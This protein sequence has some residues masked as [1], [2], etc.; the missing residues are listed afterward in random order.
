MSRDGGFEVGDRST[1]TLSDTR[2][3]RAV[4]IAGPWTVP[5]WDAIVDASWSKGERVTLD[6]A[7]LRLPSV[8]RPLIAKLDVYRDALRTVGLL[9]GDSRI[10]QESWAVWFD[11]ANQRR[12]AKR[13]RDRDRARR[14]ADERWRNESDSPADRERPAGGPYATDRA[15]PTEPIRPTVPIRPNKGNQQPDEWFSDFG[16]VDPAGAA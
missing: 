4:A 10:R 1:A 2:L 8:Y 12:E 16:R 7:V 14:A 11:P 3:I 13:K 6:D 5:A 15:D 9:D